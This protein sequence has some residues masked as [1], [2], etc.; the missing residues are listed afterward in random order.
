MRKGRT[1]DLVEGSLPEQ[2][3]TVVGIAGQRAVA[4]PQVIE[5]LI[6]QSYSVS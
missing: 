1:H 4:V 5:D 2:L 6:T 3:L